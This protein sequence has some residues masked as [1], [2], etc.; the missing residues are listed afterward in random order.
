MRAALM[1]ALIVACAPPPLDDPHFDLFLDTDAPLAR[2]GADD[3]PRH[4][5]PIV[6]TARVE[7]RDA[8]GH[9]ACE[10]CTREFALDER[11]VAQGAFFTIRTLSAQTTLVHAI[12]FRAIS[13]RAEVEGAS[14]EVW[15][16]LP[17]PPARGARAATLMLPMSAFGR[18]LGSQQAPI[19]LADGPPVRP[20]VPW[21]PGERRACKGR[22]PDGSACVEGGAFWMGSPNE[23]ALQ[24]LLPPRVVALAPFFIDLTEVGVRAYRDGGG[25]PAGLVA[26]TGSTSGSSVADFC[27]FTPEPSR[28]DDYP[29]NC[30]RFDAAR[31]FCKLRSGDLLTEA[32]Y[33][34]VAS[35]QVGLPFPWGHD[36]PRCGDAVLARGPASERFGATAGAFDTTCRPAGGGDAALEAI[37]FSLPIHRPSLG[38]DILRLRNGA[39]VQDLV[40]NLSE[41][42][43]DSW[44]PRGGSCW[45]DPKVA[46]DPL[47][48]A[49]ELH[50]VRG[51]SWLDTL[52]ASEAWSR[53]GVAGDPGSTR[54]GVGFRCAYPDR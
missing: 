49:G 47:C 50:T 46:F 7:L 8:A 12:L 43:L 41:W 40:G 3:D 10:T 29:V 23:S 36:R 26:S 48:T 21:A 11:V 52:A 39:V 53:V 2:G 33:E 20:R 38:R 30:I 28:Y 15:A 31:A 45:A 32:Q 9:L 25:D 37:G 18:A 27:T 24:R 19:E 5:V 34:Y 54:I 6:D 44:Q 17:A 51:G 16:R 35:A 42:T 4:S 13:V 22:A 1:A 14:I